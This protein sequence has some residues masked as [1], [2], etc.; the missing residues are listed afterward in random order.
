MF[1][2]LLAMTTPYR[3][4]DSFCLLGNTP[5]SCPGEK[6]CTE[7]SLVWVEMWIN[8]LEEKKETGTSFGT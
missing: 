4:L 8:V 3:I 5:S 2:L 1:M 6:N 7:R